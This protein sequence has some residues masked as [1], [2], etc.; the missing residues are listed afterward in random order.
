M[1]LITTQIL[2]LFQFV[3]PSLQLTH[4]AIRLEKVE[5]ILMYELR[6]FRQA[7]LHTTNFAENVQ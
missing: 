6:F 2:S 3:P 5:K 4:V 1:T 7:Q